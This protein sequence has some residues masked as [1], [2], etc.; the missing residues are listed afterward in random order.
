M[1]TFCLEGCDR[2]PTARVAG[3]V[4]HQ[5]DLAGV[6]ALVDQALASHGQH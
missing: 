4:L 6:K 5:A 1:A 2:G 3:Q